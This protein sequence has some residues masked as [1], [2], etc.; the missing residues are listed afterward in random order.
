[1]QYMYILIFPSFLD[2]VA[3]KMM[4]MRTR[5]DSLVIIARGKLFPFVTESGSLRKHHRFFRHLVIRCYKAEF[6]S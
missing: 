5:T 2:K 6:F 4:L 3:L 1:M